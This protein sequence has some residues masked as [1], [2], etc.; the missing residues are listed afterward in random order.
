MKKKILGILILS[1]L[2]LVG[3]GG[4]SKEELQ[5]ENSTLI[6][7]LNDAEDK[8]S[9]L[10]NTLSSLNGEGG[11]LTG[12][13]ETADGSGETFNSIGGNILF[14][15]EL[16]YTGS[17][18]APNTASVNLSS[19]VTIKPSDNWI[20]QMNGTTTKYTHPDGVYGT[21]KIVNISEPKKGDVIEEEMITPFTDE[22]PYTSIVNSKVYLEDVWRGMSTEMTVLNNNKPA[23]IKAGLVGHSDTALIYSFYY[24]G[25]K[26]ATKNEIINNLIKT[27]KFG[28]L[29]VRIE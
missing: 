20:I 9:N 12:I 26:S 28:E 13:S 24:N 19:R 4:V 3:C 27:I 16:T 10:E 6:M 17:S 14:P 1:M 8:I 18:Q 11:S 21:I 25:D 5:E 15:A 2:S 29:E 23:V 7:Q 22:I